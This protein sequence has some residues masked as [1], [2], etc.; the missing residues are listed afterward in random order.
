MRKL[1]VVRPSR[2]FFR[3]RLPAVLLLGAQ[4]RSALESYRQADRASPLRPSN[5]RRSICPTSP[6]PSR[7]TVSSFPSSGRYSFS[8]LLRDVNHIGETTRK[9]YRFRGGRAA[10]RAGFGLFVVG[11]AARQA[12][13]AEPQSVTCGQRLQMCLRLCPSLASSKAGPG[14]GMSSASSLAL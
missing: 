8:D 2:A 10:R 7:R 14:G 5:H 1:K 13:A 9:A 11:D 12:F 4:F 3:N 6:S